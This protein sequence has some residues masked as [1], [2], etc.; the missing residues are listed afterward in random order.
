MSAI[1][2]T[3][4]FYALFGATAVLA[5]G[6]GVFAA[7]AQQKG[8]TVPEPKCKVTPVEAIRIARTKVPGRAL[9]AN[10]EYAE[11]KWIYAVMIVSGKTL[12]EV[13]VDPMSGKIGDIE[14][15]T[16]DDEAKEVRS[17]LQNALD[18]KVETKGEGKEKNEKPKK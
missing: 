16:P 2:K 8:S 3:V 14:T 15:V 18:G 10:F 12:K 7:N 1:R 11:G 6:A 5:G 4:A 9:Q 17:E 13:A